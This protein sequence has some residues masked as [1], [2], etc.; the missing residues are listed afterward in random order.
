MIVVNQCYIYQNVERWVR[1][2]IP[3]PLEP[4]LPPAKTE[5]NTK[6]NVGNFMWHENK[7]SEGIKAVW[8][9]I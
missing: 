7:Q 9:A 2:T 1:P 3:V 5:N 4:I 8:D 6:D